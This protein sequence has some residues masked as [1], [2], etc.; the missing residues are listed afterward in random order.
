VFC[1]PQTYSSSFFSPTP[2]ALCAPSNVQRSHRHTRK[3]P[4]GRRNPLSTG[5][6]A[7][8][9]RFYAAEW[10]SNSC[11]TSSD[12]TTSFGGG[13]SES[14]DKGERSG[15][16]PCV[17]ERRRRKT[18]TTTAAAAATTASPPIAMP[19][20]VPNEGAPGDVPPVGPCSDG[21][22]PLAVL[23]LPAT[24][25]SAWDVKS[26]SPCRGYKNGGSSSS[27]SQ[28]GGKRSPVSNFKLPTRTWQPAPQ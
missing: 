8:S 12:A 15:A 9:R 22:G 5:Q 11:S 27:S 24:P 16:R 7:G 6:P 2:R 18:T 20:K 25:A 26:Q 21:S 17:G 23:P 28:C 10:P 4:R 14:S 1:E 3:R 19:T 13:A